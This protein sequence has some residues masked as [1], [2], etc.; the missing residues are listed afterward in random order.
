[1]HT[2]ALSTSPR[3]GLPSSPRLASPALGCAAL[4]AQV[5]EWRQRADTTIKEKDFYY[6]KLRNIELLCQIPLPEGQGSALVRTRMT[7]QPGQPAGGL[8]A[9]AAAR[10]GR[11]C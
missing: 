2:P 5:A 8:P 1:M 4:P 10:L 6:S 9:G 11:R 7:W 3:P